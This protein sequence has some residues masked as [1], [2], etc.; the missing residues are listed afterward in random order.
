MPGLAKTKDG[1][2]GKIV[3]I[4]KARAMYSTLDLDPIIDVRQ[5]IVMGWVMIGIGLDSCESKLIRLR[6]I[7]EKENSL[8]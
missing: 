6:N 3:G 2:G 7:Q 8:V 1:G 4:L 5:E